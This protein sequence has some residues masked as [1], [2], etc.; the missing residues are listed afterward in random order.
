MDRSS[1]MS[2]E[3]TGDLQF[4]GVQVSLRRAKGCVS[5]RKGS[6]IEISPVQEQ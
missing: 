5:R 6:L 4:A 3:A 1:I 2:R